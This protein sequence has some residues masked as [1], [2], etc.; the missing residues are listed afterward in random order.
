MDKENLVEARRLEALIEEKTNQIH[1]RESE[2][3]E[4]TAD[5]SISAS[6]QEM[7]EEGMGIL[8]EESPDLERLSADVV[9]I[10]ALCQSNPDLVGSALKELY[11]KMASADYLNGT[12]QYADL[13]NTIEEYLAENISLL[14]GTFSVEEILEEIEGVD[15]ASFGDE[16]T[17]KDVVSNPAENAAALIGLAMF[18]EQTEGRISDLAELLV[19]KTQRLASKEHT[20]VY[21]KLTQETSGNYAPADRIAEYIGYRY[22]WNDNKKRATL[23]L[24]KQF[25]EFQAFETEVKQEKDQIS[26]LS[27]AAKFQSTVYLPGEYVTEE[28]GCRIYEVF[29]TGYCVLADTSIMETASKVCDALIRKGGG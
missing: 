25:Y 2:N 4:E 15:G 14:D 1:N 3:P 26:E 23:T 24:G 11:E 18:Q 19:G 5:G 28:F 17:R 16:E 6:I 8:E 10:G 12:S 20:F 27:E 9:G 29:G 7:K 13:M 21:P 22:V